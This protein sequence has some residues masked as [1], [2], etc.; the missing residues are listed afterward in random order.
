MTVSE[1]A[2]DMGLRGVDVVEM[3]VDLGVGGQWSYVILGQ[4]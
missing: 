4:N 3:Y 1:E 2:E